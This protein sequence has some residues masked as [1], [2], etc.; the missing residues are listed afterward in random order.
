MS[1]PSQQ[2]NPAEVDSA[3]SVR[4]VELVVAALIFAFAIAVLFDS[5]RLGARWGE[6]GPQAGYFPFYIGLLIMIA[7]GSVFVRALRNPRLGAKRFVG[8]GQLRLIMMLLVPSI[9][10]V[11]LIHVVGI[12]LA[13]IVFIAFFMIWLG[14]YSV[15]R[16]LFVSIGVMVAFFLVF[17]VW[18]K[19]PLP[20]GPIEAALGLG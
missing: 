12:Y 19:V 17:E 5:W 10:Y 7:S 13:S 1:D 16:S 6:D 2:G 8:R 11:A 14:K 3:A 18:F 20:K 9:L 4:T 15:A